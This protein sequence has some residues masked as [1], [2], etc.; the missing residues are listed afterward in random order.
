MESNNS[1]MVFIC[2]T[3][4]QL[5]SKGQRAIKVKNE[6]SGNSIILGNMQ[7]NKYLFLQRYLLHF[8]MSGVNVVFYEVKLDLI[9]IIFHTETQ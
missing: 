8:D 1:L 7:V 2:E 5:N 4:H 6:S 9:Y 3:F